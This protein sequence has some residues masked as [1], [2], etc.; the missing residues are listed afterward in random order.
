MEGSVV[1]S[2]SAG[3]QPRRVSVVVRGSERAAVRKAASGAAAVA[4]ERRINH[5]VPRRQELL[6][7]GNFFFPSVLLHVAM[8]GSEIG[9]GEVN[10]KITASSVTLPH[11]RYR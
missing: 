9:S 11:C 10:R 7:E 1:V 6:Q 5:A 2:R 8:V 4:P 3:T